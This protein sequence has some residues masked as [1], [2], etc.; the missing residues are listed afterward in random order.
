MT[1]Y[2]VPAQVEFTGQ[3]K[4]IQKETEKLALLSVAVAVDL[5]VLVRWTGATEIR[6]E[7]DTP[8]TLS[9]LQLG[10]TLKIKGLFTN[11]WILAHQIE[12]IAK[13]NQF[14]F[15][16]K[17]EDVDT[18]NRKIEVLGFII[19]VAATVEIKTIQGVPLDFSDLQSGL[20]VEVE[21]SADNALLVASEVKI[22][23]RRPERIRFE[24]IIL[25]IDG[26]EVQVEIEGIGPALVFMGRDTKIHG[27]LEVG[28][29]VRLLGSFNN[30]LSVSASEI[31]VKQLLEAVPYQLAMGLQ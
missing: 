8:L 28:A 21:G 9:E 20:F 24:G 19:Q 12:I 10:T 26:A 2:A 18:A 3:L 25:S 22:V 29:V 31:D 7:N 16:G 15:Q 6:D 27:V 5:E 30:D 4:S 23:D 1:L 11:H 14:G 17:I 13:R